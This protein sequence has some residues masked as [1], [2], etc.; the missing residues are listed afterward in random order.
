[1]AVCWITNIYNSEKDPKQWNFQSHD[2]QNNGVVKAVGSDQGVNLDNGNIAKIEPDTNYYTDFCGIPWFYDPLNPGDNGRRFKQLWW[3]GMKGNKV[4]FY[5]E[6]INDQSYVT[7]YN[8]KTGNNI[9]H[10][11]VPNG[12]DCNFKIIIQQNHLR[13]ASFA[14][15]LEAT[16]PDFLTQIDKDGKFA[17]KIFDTAGHLIRS[18]KG[19]EVE[20]G[21][22]RPAFLDQIAE[23]AAV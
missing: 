12:V 1:M 21:E 5:N 13:R 3:S 4:A 14:F 16:P 19:S 18:F 10:R 6:V 20:N 15:D 17:A 9:A 22:F 8:S 2:F 23:M 7:F 11:A